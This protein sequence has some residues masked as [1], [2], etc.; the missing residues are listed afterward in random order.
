M[1]KIT[2]GKLIEANAQMIGTKDFSKYYMCL[3]FKTGKRWNF[4]GYYIP[5]DNQEYTIKRVKD[6]IY[7]MGK[8]NDGEVRYTTTKDVRDFLKI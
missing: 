2:V 1:K 6:N 8:D 5:K 3:E 4:S 7:L